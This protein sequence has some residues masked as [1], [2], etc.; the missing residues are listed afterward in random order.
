MCNVV[1]YVGSECFSALRLN[2]SQ[3]DM[4]RYVHIRADM[5]RYVQICA[6]TCRYVQICADM[7]R[8]VQICPI[9][10]DK[11]TIKY[12][13]SPRSRQKKIVRE[14]TRNYSTGWTATNCCLTA[15]RGGRFCLLHNVQ[16]GPMDHPTSSSELT[17]VWHECPK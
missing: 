2:I 1:S 10:T 11:W 8:Y 3:E 14:L 6:D 5:C 13:V 15:V 12:S 9:F 16:T 17:N 4:C 7:C